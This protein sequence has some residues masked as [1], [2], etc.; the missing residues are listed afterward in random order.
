MNQRK[1]YSLVTFGPFDIHSERSIRKLRCRW[2]ILLMK[3]LWPAAR[4]VSKLASD[5]GSTPFWT[6]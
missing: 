5:T 4:P 1:H 3:A 6:I 2:E